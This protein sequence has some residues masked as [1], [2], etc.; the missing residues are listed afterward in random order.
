MTSVLAVILILLSALF[1]VG[2]NLLTKSSA[3]PRVF[4][5]LKGAL[6]ATASLVVLPFM[7]LGPVLVEIWDYVL[8]SGII[9]AVYI[10]ALSSAYE[11]GDLS[12]VY[13]IARSAPAFVP[14]AAVLL[15]GEFISPSGAAG[16]AIVV[17]SVFAL[18]FRDAPGTELGRLLG[19][20]RSKEGVWALVTLCA[21]VAYSLVDKAGMVA[22]RRVEEIPAGMRG[23]VYFL[24]EAFVTYAILWSSL[25]VRCWS[26][27]RRVL[28][29]EWPRV[30]LAA[31][32]TMASYSLVLHVMQTEPVSYIVALRQSS[33]LLAVLV[34]WF[35]LKEPYGKLRVAAGTAIVVGLVLVATA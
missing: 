34:G 15:L 33:V 9:H 7:P 10:L 20:L 19:A 35:F 32:G 30:V 31:V 11:T 3:D 26:S 6:M 22:L 16:I 5:L 21:V 4:S 29:K 27:A 1:H 13:P 23:P 17:V 8:V 2:W 28:S 14:I 24:L 25:G 12:Y 18:Q